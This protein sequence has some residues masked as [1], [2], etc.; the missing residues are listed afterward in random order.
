MFDKA[1][2]QQLSILEEQSL[3][4]S[5]VNQGIIVSHMSYPQ[6]IVIWSEKMLDLPLRFE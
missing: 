2:F 6:E 1:S 3:S 5:C 4:I